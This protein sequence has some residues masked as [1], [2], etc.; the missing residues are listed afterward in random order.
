MAGIGCSEQAASIPSIS[1][2]RPGIIEHAQNHQLAEE[3]IRL[4]E[5]V[6]IGKQIFTASFNT[7]DGSGNS[8]IRFIADQ[9][10]QEELFSR[11]NR[12]SGPDANACSGCHNTPIVGGGGD[13][14]AN[15]F[16][17]AHKFPNINFDKDS[18][19]LSE[20][21]T[22]STVGNER[23]TISM[24][25]SGIIE[26]LA[27]EMTT[28]L[29]GLRDDALL[30][31]VTTQL[32]VTVELD[33][34][35]VK[36]G[37]LTVW[38]DG[39]IDASNVQGVDQDLIIKPFGQKGVYVSLREFTLDAAELH[40]GL[41]AEDRVGVDNDADQDGITNELTSADITALTLFQASLPPPLIQLPESEHL[42]FQANRGEILF[43]EIGCAVCHKP[44]L[45]LDNPIYTEPNPF[46]PPGSTAS[47]TVPE[48]YQLD[49]SSHVNSTTVQPTAQ[50][51]YLI[52]AY[53]DLKRHDMG[54]LL[55]NEQIE[56]RFVQ[57]SVWITRKLWGAASE[58]PFLHHGR[59]TLVGE[60]IDAHQGEAG[61]SRS[62]YDGLTSE[63]QAAI[64]EFIKTFQFLANQ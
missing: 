22:L 61:E 19:D 51:T 35:G 21:H 10:E 62:L 8:K 48:I 38:P 23:G 2:D 59:A 17:L 40:H 7:L 13:N 30:A 25:G 28:E 18:G 55:A 44:F 27:R 64:V 15:V 11:F 43:N 57:S 16:V 5:L 45:E 1:G 58:P 53:T 29:H 49:L 33:T 26:L 52:W 63:E 6:G 47:I 36:F 50:G 56:Q 4:R 60:A 34:K 9:T 37:A 12:I 54:P 42:K 14:A 39:L 3:T 20:S 41:Q 46:N 31:A 32:P 24:F